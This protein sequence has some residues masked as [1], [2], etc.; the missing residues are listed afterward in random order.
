MNCNNRTYFDSFGFE[1]I[2]E[3]L[4]YLQNI[5]KMQANDSIMCEYFCNASGLLCILGIRT[6]LSQI[7]LVGPLLFQRYKMNKI[8][9][10][11][12]WQERKSCLKCI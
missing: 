11:F 12:Y 5:C 1:H 10:T 4:K 6:S 7:P 9:N 8:V 3:K 2:L